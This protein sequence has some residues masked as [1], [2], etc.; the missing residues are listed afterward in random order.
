MA[1]H[2]LGALAA[3]KKDLIAKACDEIIAGKLDDQFPL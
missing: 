3:D 1:N 2:E